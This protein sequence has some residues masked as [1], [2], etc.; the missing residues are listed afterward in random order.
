[1]EQFGLLTIAGILG[2][3]ISGSMGQGSA[4]TILPFFV[5]FNL[6]GDYKT[7]I[8]TALLTNLAPL[9]L[10]GIREYYKKGKIDIKVSLYLMLIISLFTYI[11]TKLTLSIDKHII[12]KASAVVYSICSIFWIY[13]SYT[14]K[15]IN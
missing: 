1:M 5:I 11:G 4:L 2:G 6:V 10:F 3:L 13:V 8:G 12:V 15:F 7:S 14:G 9:S